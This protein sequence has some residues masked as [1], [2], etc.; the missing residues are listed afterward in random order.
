MPPG[1][2]V[3]RVFFLRLEGRDSFCV[4][5]FGNLITESQSDCAFARVEDSHGYLL[6]S[7]RRNLSLL[8]FTGISRVQHPFPLAHCLWI[9]RKL[10]AASPI[11][12]NLAKQA[13]MNLD[14][15]M[16]LTYR[17]RYVFHL[18]SLAS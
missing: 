3:E 17:K 18:P 12:L 7:W 11:Q 10:C 8:P 14:I 2:S 1:V 16:R 6:I 4:Y 5:F 15:L 13:V 9:Y